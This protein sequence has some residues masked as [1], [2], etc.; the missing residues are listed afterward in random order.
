MKYLLLP[1]LVLVL[2]VSAYAGGYNSCG[3]E[4]PYFTVGPLNGQ[5]GWSGSAGG[6]G[7]EPV[8]QTTVVEGRQAVK[9]EVPDVQGAWSSMDIAIPTVTVTGN[10]IVTVSYDIFHPL[11]QEGK[12]QNLWWWWW[13][14]GEP[15]YGL[16]WD[17]GSTY[18]HGWNPGSSSAPNVYGQW[19]NVTMVW[20]F[21]QMKAY[22][23]YNGT[24]VDNGIPITNISQ[25]TG[26]SI[27]LAHDAATGTG[28]DVAYIDCFCISVQ[29]IPEPGSMLALG[30]GFLGLIG[31]AIRRRR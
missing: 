22:S 24:L 14:S 13:D 2:A 27:Y 29:N 19:T 9:M 10:E 26:W 31:F 28:G 30:S 20:D 15:T 6:G 11:N 17:Q 8:V 23:W 18:P 3:F 21:T 1:V 7:F 4:P 25:L 5:D 12:I 16:Q